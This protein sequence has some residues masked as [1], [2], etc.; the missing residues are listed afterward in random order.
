[1]N[2]TAPTPTRIG[3]IA[4][5][6]RY[7]MMFCEAARQ[8]QVE[9]LAVVGMHDE[10]DPQIENLCDSLDWVYVGQLNKAIK[11][12]K[13]HDVAH[14]VFAGQIKPGRLFKRTPTLFFREWRLSLRKM[15]LRYCR[16][17]H[18]WKVNWPIRAQSASNH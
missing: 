15:V 18:F 7:P 5:R 9:H 1:M 8:H 12:L 4:G 6:G 3:L 11:A 17:R 16:P 2:T 10:T 13:R 14:V